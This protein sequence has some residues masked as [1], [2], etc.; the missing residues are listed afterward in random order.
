ME[1]RLV[2]VAAASLVI[3]MVAVFGLASGAIMRSFAMRRV[4]GPPA[5]RCCWP[6]PARS[7]SM[8]N[9]TGT[10]CRLRFQSGTGGLGEIKALKKRVPTFW[11]SIE[12]RSTC[13][14]FQ[15]GLIDRLIFNKFNAL[16]SRQ[17]GVPRA[18]SY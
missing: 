13:F 15:L 1:H 10:Q 11:V 14:R 3:A 7:I 9:E 16:A 5:S 8:I 12:T 17:D 6:R 4:R 18:V 2:T